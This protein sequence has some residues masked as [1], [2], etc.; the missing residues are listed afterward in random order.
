MGPVAA[1]SSAFLVG[2]CAPD[3]VP[4]SDGTAKPPALELPGTCYEGQYPTQIY[5]DTGGITNGL[6]WVKQP[7]EA[8]DGPFVYADINPSAPVFDIHITPDGNFKVGETNGALDGF[9]AEKLLGSLVC[10][11]ELLLATMSN[12]ALKSLQARIFENMGGDEYNASGLRDF[13]YIPDGDGHKPTIYGFLPTDEILDQETLLVVW[14]HELLHAA[15]NN[16][17]LNAQLQPAERQIVQQACAVIRKSATAQAGRNAYRII[18]NLSAL[19]AQI[20]PQYRAAFQTV[21]DA[22]LQGTYDQ[23]PIELDEPKEVAACH[24]QSPMRAVLQVVVANGGDAKEFKKAAN[25]LDGDIV[26]SINDGWNDVLEE[27]TIYS[28]FKEGNYMAF[29]RSNNEFGHPVNSDEVLTTFLNAALSF[30]DRVAEHMSGMTVKER[31]AALA[32]VSAAI[33]TIKNNN[34]NSPGL[35]MWLDVRYSLF[36]DALKRYE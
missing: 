29:G 3:A 34:P 25:A 6:N 13:M 20:D 9:A 19:Q 10:S 21:I 16:G 14:R 30:P 17:E 33:A 4:T 12:G 32:I 26:G 5:V 1:L 7:Y 27:S 23:L 24:V 36:T 22:M 28:F 2:A 15:L 11:K 35:S 18:Q 8:V 31:D